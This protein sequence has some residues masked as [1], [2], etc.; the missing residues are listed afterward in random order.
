MFSNEWMTHLR[1]MI[2]YLLLLL[3]LKPSLS[4][5]LKSRIP[6]ITIWQWGIPFIL[7]YLSLIQCDFFS[8]KQT[9]IKKNVKLDNKIVII[10]IIPFMSMKWKFH[11]KKIFLRFDTQWSSMKFYQNQNYITYLISRNWFNQI[12]RIECSHLFGTISQAHGYWHL[13]WTKKKNKKI[14]LKIQWKKQQ[15]QPKLEKNCCNFSFLL[16]FFRFQTLSFFFVFVLPKL[17]HTHTY[18]GYLILEREYSS[19]SGKIVI[20]GLVVVVMWSK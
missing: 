19:G 16:L 13:K 4:L 17:Q 20:E 15:Q 11:W 3:P 1:M 8:N 18:N 9:R 2:R 12:I 6:R 5:L 14:S 7:V 10:I